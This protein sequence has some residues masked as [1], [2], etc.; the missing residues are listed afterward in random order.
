MQLSPV[1]REIARFRAFARYFAL[2]FFASTLLRRHTACADEFVPA[3]GAQRAQNRC[4][5]YDNP[6]PQN[7]YLIDGAG[8]WILSEMG[9]HEASGDWRPAFKES[10][11][12]LSGN[13]SYGYGCACASVIVDKGD[14]RI[15]RV[16]SSRVRRL[17]ACYSDKT[18]AK[19]KR[20]PLSPLER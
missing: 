15:V 5:W 16:L 12:V 18:L 19:Q 8:E 4:G 3:H 17:S 1:H 10:D 6:T 20:R 11:W 7:F 13:G 14:R 2:V 9:R